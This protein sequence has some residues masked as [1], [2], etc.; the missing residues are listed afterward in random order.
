MKPKNKACRFAGICQLHSTKSVTCN[1]EARAA[2]YYG[3]GRAAGCYRYMID[4]RRFLCPG[5]SH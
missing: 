4:L 1:D 2:A 5:C 3:P